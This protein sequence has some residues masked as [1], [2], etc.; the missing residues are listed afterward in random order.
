LI[1]TG[2]GNKGDEKFTAIYGVERLPSMEQSLSGVGLES[3]DIHLVINTHFHFDHAGGNTMRLQDGRIVPTFAK[4]DYY[5]QRG[6]WNSAVTPNERTRRSYL[7]EN[8]DI[9]S[10]LGRLS[11]V[12][13][14]AEIVPGIRLV[15]TSRAHRA[16]PVG[17]RGI[18][19]EN[20]VLSRRSHPDD[21]PSPVALCDGL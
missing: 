20:R 6:E 4:A 10:K 3:K 18:R 7:E 14:D 9:L 21:V 1:D 13:G 15:K 5:V 12:D 2:I 17:H 8:Y 16:S 11:L 19:R